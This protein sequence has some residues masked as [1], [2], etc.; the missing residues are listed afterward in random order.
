MIVFYERD[1]G[2]HQVEFGNMVIY[3][4]FKMPFAYKTKFHGLRIRRDAFEGHWGEATL[5]CIKILLISN[6]KY[7]LSSEEVFNYG[8]DEQFKRTV[9]EMAKV[10]SKKG[11]GLC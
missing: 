9:L 1:V 4:S 5:N 7:I 10:I 2:F 8:I 6:S 3:Y 11:L